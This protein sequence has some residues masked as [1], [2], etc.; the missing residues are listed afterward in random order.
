MEYSAFID[1]VLAL[2]SHRVAGQPL[3]LRE[4]MF[5]QLTEFFARQASEPYQKCLRKGF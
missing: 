1:E 3:S 5:P 4:W 2:Y